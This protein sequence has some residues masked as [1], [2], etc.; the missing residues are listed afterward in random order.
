VK[1][2]TGR[3]FPSYRHLPGATPHPERSPEGHIYGVLEPAAKPL[4]PDGWSG[5]EDFLYGVDLFN[6]GYFWEAHVFW[7]RLWALEETPR[8]VRRVLQSIIQTAAACLKARQGEIAGARKLLARAGLERFEGRE[9]GIDVHV[10]AR[11]AR[12]FVEEDREPPHLVLST[13]ETG[14]RKGDAP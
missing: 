12:R 11:Q 7:E 14:D 2:Y 4:T 8:E 9:L 13:A 1:R 5:N 10:L 3:P 6:A